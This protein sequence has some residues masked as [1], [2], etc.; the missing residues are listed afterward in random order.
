MSTE[1]M[2]TP[3]QYANVFDRNPDGQAVLDDLTRIFLGPLWHPD[4]DERAR[5]I[6]QREVLEHI[7]AR[8][9]AGSR[10]GG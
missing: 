6:G 9:E 3:L 1:P 7:H 2:A 10:P 8:I 4:A 5:R